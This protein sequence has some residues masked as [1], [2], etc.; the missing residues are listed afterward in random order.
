MYYFDDQLIAIHRGMNVR[1]KIESA[2]TGMTDA[3]I[4]PQVWRVY[5]PQVLR[6]CLHL[7]T[8]EAPWEIT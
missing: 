4:F 8:N 6:V 5:Y 1:F 7:K 3:Q 2:L